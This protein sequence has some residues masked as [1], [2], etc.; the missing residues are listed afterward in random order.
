MSCSKKSCAFAGIHC[1]EVAVAYCGLEQVFVRM[2]GEAIF[3]PLSSH[4]EPLSISVLLH[5]DNKPYL[6]EY[7]SKDIYPI[8]P[9]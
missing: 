3:N 1:D 9:R 2:Y 8:P 7:P 5:H 6:N 4:D